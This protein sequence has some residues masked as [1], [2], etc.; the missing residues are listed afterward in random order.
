MDLIVL[1]I[2]L[3]ASKY[4]YVLP[5]LPLYST[6]TPPVL[7]GTHLSSSVLTCPPLSSY[8][9]SILP[10]LPLYSTVLHMYSTVLT[11]PHQYSHV[12]LC[13]HLFSSVLSILPYLPSTSLTSTVLSIL[14]CP[15]L[16]SHSLH[17][18]SLY[19]LVL[20]TSTAIP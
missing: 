7:N 1:S 5:Y 20:P 19:S 16:S 9:L 15:P 13:T 11:C 4:S 2:S 8:V 6:C 18:L 17:R 3:T 14:P 12:F 10:Y